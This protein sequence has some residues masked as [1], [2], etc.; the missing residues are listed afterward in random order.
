[1]PERFLVASSTLPLRSRKNIAEAMAVGICCRRRFRS[2]SINLWDIFAWLWTTFVPKASTSAEQTIKKFEVFPRGLSATYDTYESFEV[3]RQNRT[4]VEKL[5]SKSS[6]AP[7][8]FLSQTTRP[9]DSAAQQA[10]DWTLIFCQS[11][12]HWELLSV[13]EVCDLE[14]AKRKKR[15]VPLRTGLALYYVAWAVSEELDNYSRAHE[16]SS[17]ERITV[18]ANVLSRYFWIRVM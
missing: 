14:A 5:M 17:R 9:K 16:N 1:M 13:A 11:R 6:S 7:D 15:R 2:F 4:S 18:K 3:C 8:L 10:R 12:L